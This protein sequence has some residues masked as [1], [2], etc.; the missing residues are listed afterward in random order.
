MQHLCGLGSD[1]AAVMLG[2]RGGVSKLLKDQVPF[3]VANYCIAHRLALAAGQ[4][5]NEITYLKRFKAVLDQLYRFYENSPVC[6]A[7]CL[8]SIQEV[9][10]DP[11]LKLTQA[12]DVRW[13]SHDKAVSNLRRCLPSV[14]TS[15][16]REA[17]ERYNAEASGLAAFV[18]TY[19][20][21]SALYM[22]C[23]VLPP[24]AGLSRAFQ[25]HDIDFT[26]VKPLV[27]GTKAAIDALLL[28]PGDCYSSLPTVLPELEE[29]GVQQPT[30]HQ[31]QQFKQHVYDKYLETLSQYITNR[32]PDMSLLEEFSSFDASNIPLDLSLQPNHGSEHLATLLDHYGTHSVFDSQATK[33]EFRTFNSVI[34]SNPGLKQLTMRQLMSHVIKTPEFNVMFPN[35]M[36][37]A[38]I[39]LL[40]LM[41]TVDCER[42]FSTLSRVKTKLRN[43]LSNRILNTYLPFPWRDLPLLNFPMMMHVIFGPECRIDEFK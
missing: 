15:L 18:K 6:S 34:V 40:L 9:L 4:A 13:L 7:G 42:G 29:F 20:F 22:F 37:L 36:K 11:C 43:R 23:D 41:S 25:K 16:E 14:I 30:D 2:I 10:N 27:A 3:L 17:V 26:V 8:K 33:L 21:V 31:V 38:T 39:G 19:K 32:F 28:V 12:K 35:L 24:L 1:G 5:A